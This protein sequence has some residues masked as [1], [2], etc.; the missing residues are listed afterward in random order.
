MFIPTY[1]E[2]S[3]SGEGAVFSFPPGQELVK[4]N[5]HMK[6]INTSSIVRFLNKKFPVFGHI[7]TMTIINVQTNRTMKIVYSV[8][9]VNIVIFQ[10]IIFLNKKH[11]PTA[12]LIGSC[13]QLSVCSHTELNTT[14]HVTTVAGKPYHPLNQARAV[15][16]MNSHP[17]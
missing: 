3:F 6:R 14:T 17:Q 2:A 10:L 11:K 4:S 1:Y 8:K 5:T 12:C 7:N 9:C 15:E 13:I 16:Y